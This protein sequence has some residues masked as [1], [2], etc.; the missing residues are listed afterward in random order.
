MPETGTTFV[1]HVLVL[2]DSG[3]NLVC[4]KTNKPAGQYLRRWL[5]R[6]VLPQ[7][8]QT[9]NRTCHSGHARVVDE[10]V[11]GGDFAKSTGGA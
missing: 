1:H 3:V 9:D 7:L 6:G 2:F 8:Q 4:M 11:E 5:V 10:L